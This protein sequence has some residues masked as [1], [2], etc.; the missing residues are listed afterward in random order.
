MK[1]HEVTTAR[2]AKVLSEKLPKLNQVD[3]VE[4][5][6]KILEQLAYGLLEGMSFSNDENCQ[7]GLSAIIYNAFEIFDNRAFYNPQQT[8]KLALA[9]QKFTESY[10]TVYS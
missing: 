4:D 6:A 9:T 7:I 8:M 2:K 10:N 3:T 5:L 1:Q